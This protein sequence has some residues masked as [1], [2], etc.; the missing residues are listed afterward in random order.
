MKL[1]DNIPIPVKIW[2]PVV[3]AVTAIAIVA[4]IG[5]VEIRGTMLDDRREKI[6]AVV[7]SAYAITAHYHNQAQ[8]GVLSEEEAKTRAKDAVREISYDGGNYV[9]INDMQGVS[10]VIRPKPAQE[11]KDVSDFEDP[12]GVFFIRELTET[13]RAD[14]SGYVAYAWSK[15]GS[16]TPVGKLTYASGFKPWGWLIGTGIYVDDV[17]SS[18]WRH[19]ATLSA[20]AFGVAL[21]LSGVAAAVIRTM[22]R[23]LSRLTKTMTRLA[24]G[25]HAIDIGD[26]GRADE[27]GAMATAVEVFRQNAET[28]ETADRERRQSEAQS[29]YRR[30]QDMMETLH[31]MVDAGVCCNK[32]VTRLAR[33]RQE[34]GEAKGQAESMAAAVEELVTSIQQISENSENA[35]KDAKNAENAATQGVE[36]SSRAVTSMEQIVAAVEE[37]ASEVN[38]LAGES[39]RIGE[40]VGQIEDIAD[41]TNLLA[42]NATIEAA[43]A[44]DAGKGFAVVASEVKNLA[45]QTGKSTE[46]IRSRIESLRLKME[47]IVTSMNRGS[48]AVGEGRDVI[49][50]LGGQLEDISARINSVTMKTAEISGILSQQTAA[51]NDVS[52]GTGRI[53]QVSAANDTE[54]ETLLGSMDNV[55]QSLSANIGGFAELGMDRAIVEIGKNDHV[56]FVKRVVDTIVGRARLTAADLPDHHNCRLGKWYYAVENPVILNAP[57]FK[58]LEP[59]HIRVHDLGKT[60]LDAFHGGDLDAALS[61]VE[62]LSQ[63][64]DEVLGLL[65]DLAQELRGYEDEGAQGESENQEEEKPIPIA[66]E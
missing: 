55:N 45:N 40:I 25:D 38:T 54:I 21:M 11:G 20:I 47:G 31:G 39:E 10:L 19:V 53:A 60:A 26:T 37:A 44:G 62:A 42:L 5:L 24:S 35:T 14:G 23:P 28:L 64:S 65:D 8:T 57:A 7:D 27:I 43:R 33:M 30:K 2:T 63:V 52:Q 66:A 4:A 16:D 59:P 56:M 18:F 34:I 49:T 1:L 6:R 48:R 46:D 29:E 3:L 22:S 41:Q 36:A 9:F 12:N 17:S 61:H 51:A 58:R 13:V 15:P 32:S 50:S